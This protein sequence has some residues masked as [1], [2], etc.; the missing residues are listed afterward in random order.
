MTARF[1]DADPPYYYRHLDFESLWAAYPPAREFQMTVARASRDELRD[2]Q[3][4]RFKTQ[5]ARAWEIPFYQK[6]W[7]KEG[8]ESGD[9]QGLDDLVRI[10]TFTVSDLKDSLA[11]NSPWGEFIGIDPATSEPLP[12]AFHTSGGTTGDPR[13]MMFSP[14]DRE[15]MAIMG[16]RRF[17][18]QGIRPFD[19]V[20]V[21]LALGLPNAGHLARE[22]L[23][24]YSGAVP[25]MTGTGAITPTRRQVEL[26][27][28][29][30]VNVLMGLSGYLRHIG[31]VARDELKLDPASLGVERLVS[32]IGNDSREA[33]EELWGCPAFD[34]YGTNE[35]GT[36]AG[37]CEH[38]TGSH[39][40][41]DAFYPEVCD[42]A[43]MKSTEG[44][45][46]VLV[47]TSLFKHA[48]PMI[49]FNTNDI[50]VL[51]SE[52]C[53][54]GSCHRR[55]ERVLGR[56][57]LMVKLRGTNVFPEAIGALLTEY[58]SYAGEYACVVDR[59]ERGMDRMT[60]HALL[61]P[62]STASQQQVEQRLLDA[63]GVRVNI[64]FTGREE[65]AGLAQLDTAGKP[66]RLIDRRY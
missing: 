17:Y 42:P 8:I 24:K 19:R 25:I 12:I 55:M 5:L 61:K 15:V 31:L 2:I 32:W 4:R 37:E 48:A 22:S 60:V 14:I 62:G 54:C 46:G 40:Y 33:L 44:E 39:I 45:R 34:G 43:S 9:I 57:D 20:V 30:R 58:D 18:A 63:L 66:R 23:W 26:I 6:H 13:P 35:L 1:A 65:L 47:I 49:R 28:K 38:R 53:V 11:T 27:Q 56:A 41:E 21:T 7:K 3:E 51:H 52:T 10:P 16:S 29:W 36:I 64:S 50:T 59:D